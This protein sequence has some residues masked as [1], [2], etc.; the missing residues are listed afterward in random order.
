MTSFSQTS[1]SSQMPLQDKRK[2]PE[3]GLKTKDNKNILYEVQ[4]WNKWDI[5]QNKKLWEN[6]PAQFSFTTT[7]IQWPLERFA[8][9]WKMRMRQLTAVD[10]PM[11]CRS[12]VHYDKPSAWA[13]CMACDLY[14][15]YFQSRSASLETSCLTQTTALCYWIGLIAKLVNQFIRI[16]TIFPLS[17]P[18]RR[19]TSMLR[20][21]CH[22][23][24]TKAVWASVLN[25]AAERRRLPCGMFGSV[26]DQ[27]TLAT[28]QMIT[29]VSSTL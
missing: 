5:V 6:M 28:P 13:Q 15:K 18:H 2:T 24:W 8:Y 10:S 16:L 20:C 23:T 27:S 12:S 14:D 25:T 7:C 4:M 21:S 19:L 22:H 1:W 11:S 26:E 9:S 3:N 29:Y 17:N